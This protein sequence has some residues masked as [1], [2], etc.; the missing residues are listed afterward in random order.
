MSIRNQI[1]DWAKSKGLQLSDPIG[2]TYSGCDEIDFQQYR[3]D[4]FVI[5]V[6]EC[7]CY[8]YI[9]L[10]IPNNT[11]YKHRYQVKIKNGYAIITKYLF[12]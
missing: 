5:K 2:Y 1:L 11:P 8:T 9:Y 12:K 3:K 10:P 4:P 6:R 7:K